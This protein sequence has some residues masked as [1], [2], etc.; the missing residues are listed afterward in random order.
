MKAVF[1]V[2][3]SIF[4]FACID[5]PLKRQSQTT[6]HLENAEIAQPEMWL[7]IGQIDRALV[8][9]ERSLQTMET[10]KD[11]F[12]YGQAL[13]RRGRTQEALEVFDRAVLKDA[14]LR[15]SVDR[16]ILTIAIENE[17][18]AQAAQLLRDLG[19]KEDDAFARFLES[20]SETPHQIL[21]GSRTDLSLEGKTLLEVELRLE[22]NHSARFVLDTGASFSVIT[23]SLA[24]EIGIY[25]RVE[26]GVLL[27][28]EGNP[29]PASY[30]K[31]GI[32][33]LGSLRVA[34]VP[35]L[36]VEDSSL[37][38]RLFGLHPVFEARGVLGM[39]FLRHFQLSVDFESNTLSL[40]NSTENR[41]GGLALFSTGLNLYLPV[42]CE[43]EKEYAFRLDTG[44]NQ[45]SLSPWMLKDSGL[46]SKA[47]SQV[48]YV[49][50]AQGWGASLKEVAGTQLNIGAFQL[51]D[52]RL[53][54]MASMDTSGLLTGGVLGLD[55]L[56]NFRLTLD[57]KAMR[58]WL[59][60]NNKS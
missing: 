31:I 44:S 34:H 59:E 46:E 19:S 5:T 51:K 54:V 28:L 38:F 41:S 26:G 21:S 32:L 22:R 50:G 24:K 13:R 10:G 29:F 4:L 15:E 2:L 48:H 7:Q 23:Q 14:E 55:L 30:G 53:P 20:F 47:S 36:I 58:L 6:A 16:E 56:R 25:T 17:H 57:P 40:E 37:Q 3:I 35:V 12:L 11:L 9:L 52:L 43:G 60:R 1:A 49:A 45:S 18:Y 8:S 27:D 39:S 42:R 33:E